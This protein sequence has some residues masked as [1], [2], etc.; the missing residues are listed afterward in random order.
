MNYKL[1]DIKEA[2]EAELRQVINMKLRPM[3]IIECRLTGEPNTQM[4]IGKGLAV[5]ENDYCK[6]GYN[7]ITN[8]P[9]FV[10]G[11]ANLGDPSTGVPWLLATSD[12]KITKD[13]LKACKNEV[14]P[15]VSKLYPILSNYVSKHNVE[16]IRWLRWLGFTI[17]DIPV[18]FTADHQ[19]ADVFLFTKLGG[20][21]LCAQ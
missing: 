7:T 6:I 14:F 5:S 10:V 20:R 12:L 21:P 16:A 9:D 11:V 8:R 17:Y 19:V 15:E 18:S 4:A 1:I 3:D 13:W 2:T